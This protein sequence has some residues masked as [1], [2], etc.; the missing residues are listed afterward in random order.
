MRL[1][2]YLLTFF[3]ITLAQAQPRNIGS[4][5]VTGYIFPEYSLSVTPDAS[6][7]RLAIHSGENS[8]FIGRVMESS[9]SPL[10]YAIHISSR[11]GGAL[12]NANSPQTKSIP[13]MISYDNLPLVRPGT[14]P[15]LIKSSGLILDP[16]THQSPVR[17]TFAAN[18]RAEVGT[19][20]D[21]VY[22]QISA[23]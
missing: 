20:S 2:V 14:A 23:P 12:L 11:N 15:K 17:I 7:R 13:Y 16:Q 10:G 18:P 8:R 22:F 19:Y 4:V 6:A 21:T 5:Y 3:V 9:N 1:L